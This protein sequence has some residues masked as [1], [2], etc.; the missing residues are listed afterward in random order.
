MLESVLPNSQYS[1]VIQSDLLSPAQWGK[2]AHSGDQTSEMYKDSV[3]K[4]SV[5]RD[6]AVV[7]AVALSLLPHPNP[8]HRFHIMRP[9][10]FSQEHM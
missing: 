6:K 8:A 4:I 9:S 7:E 1:K 3:G 10:F 2:E 5:G